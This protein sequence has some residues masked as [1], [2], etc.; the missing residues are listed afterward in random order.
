MAEERV[1]KIL[2]EDGQ[3]LDATKKVQDLG[4]SIEG[5]EKSNESTSKS[6]TELSEKAALTYDEL[7]T[8]IQEQKDITIEFKKELISLQSQ[9]ANTSKTDLSGQK[10]LRDKIIQV[11]GAIEEQGVALQD[12]T[13]QK[14]KAKESNAD[15]TKGLNKTSGIVGLL[16]RHTGGLAGSLLDVA[17]ASKLSGAAMRTALISTGVG[18]LV[19]A[20][21][22]IVSNWDSITNAIDKSTKKLQKQLDL[23]IEAQKT[24]Q[25]KL[26]LINSEIKLNE[27]LGK[28]NEVLQAQRIEIVKTLRE[29]NAEELAILEKQALKLKTSALELTTREK[30]LKTILNTASAGSGDKFILDGQLEALAQYN[31][32]QDLILQPK[33]K[34]VD[35]DIKIFDL[36]N[37]EGKAREKA[38]SVDAGIEQGISDAYN[39]QKAKDASLLQALKEGTEE[40][41]EFTNNANLE[42]I[43][44]FFKTE[45]AKTAITADGQHKRTLIEENEA[46]ARKE[47]AQIEA[48]AKLAINN[49]YIDLAIGGINVLKQAFEGN[50][51]VQKA[52]LIAESLT[53]VARIIINTQA[54]NAKATLASP[55]TA[56]Q[57]FVAIN[58]IGAG[59]GIAANLVATKK[60]LSALGGGNVSASGN[61]SGGG[62]TPSAPSF[63]VVGTSG[64]NQLAQSI[65]GQQQ[66]IETYIVAAN[67]TSQQALDR[68]IT[69]TASIF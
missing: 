27:K 69:E 54:A 66:P 22:L 60:A 39:E 59:I 25:L 49:A 18:A 43:N 14:N 68:N 7:G 5:L 53:G 50:K 42:E 46:I 15:Y 1:I 2:V 57:P 19:V 10:L 9:L 31:D 61:T 48:D 21:G 35:F 44:A 16:N 28:G 51:K 23:S 3:I 6:F 34:Q 30:I 36:E 24:T 62:S 52:L 29:Q 56:G 47:I 37:P 41:K 4:H 63:N 38:V 32:I 17:R 11:K 26:D 13:N 58:T 55:L 65:Q 67:V 20:L 33:K 45:Q 40:L 12:L 8:I 64:V